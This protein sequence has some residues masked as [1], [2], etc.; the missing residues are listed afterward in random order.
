MD[1]PQPTFTLEKRQSQS[2][3]G[4][5]DVGYVAS[6][7]DTVYTPAGPSWGSTRIGTAVVVEYRAASTTLSTGHSDPYDRLFGQ[8]TGG[9]GVG[10]PERY[11]G[12]VG[13]T[14]RI[15]EAARRR[16]AE[17]TRVGTDGEGSP[18]TVEN[19]SQEGGVNYYR[20]D[21]LVPMDVVQFVIDTS[22]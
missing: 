21:V 6:G 10:A 7:A 9:D 5:Q 22:T 4:Q 18:I 12:V 19:R 14:K 2:R 1:V 16:T 17:W 8:R 13:E 20:A 3:L 15:L 11:D